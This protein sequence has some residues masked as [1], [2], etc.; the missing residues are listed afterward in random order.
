[1]G[2]AE[3]DRV[4]NDAV[5]FATAALQDARRA[6]AFELVASSLLIAICALI[7]HE[8]GDEALADLLTLA[9]LGDCA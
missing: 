8:S 9:M 3:R 1:M 7:R 2:D 6:G 5:Q 4:R